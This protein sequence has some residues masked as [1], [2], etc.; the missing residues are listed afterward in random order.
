MCFS[1]QQAHIHAII[2][3]TLAFALWGRVNKKT[4]VATAFICGMDSIQA[5][6]YRGLRLGGEYGIGSWQNQF[7]TVLG[8]VHIS[9]QPFFYNIAIMG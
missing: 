6:Q 5:L 1:E 2:G 9:L 4:L 8:L 7:L 3:Y